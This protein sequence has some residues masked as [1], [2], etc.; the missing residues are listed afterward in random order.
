[1]QNFARVVNG[2]AVEVLQIDDGLKPGKDLFSPDF[3]RQL[4]ECPAGTLAGA[5]YD[6]KAFSA[7]KMLLPSVDLAAYAANARWSRREGG[8]TVGGIAIRTDAVTRSEL[9]HFVEMCREKSSFTVDWKMADGTFLTLTQSAATGFMSA[10]AQF[11]GSCFAAEK[12]VLADIASGKIT[13]PAQ[14]DAIFAAVVK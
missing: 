7:R 6:G 8:M 5:A 3:A 12:S 13:A 1:M 9:V 10:I 11:T 14:I 2:I 4:V